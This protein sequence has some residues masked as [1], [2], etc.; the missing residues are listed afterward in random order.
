MR[1]MLE[2]KVGIE[3]GIDMSERVETNGQALEEVGRPPAL[4]GKAESPG[5]VA[6][7]VARI[8]YALLLLCFA[9]IALG[10]DGLHRLRCEYCH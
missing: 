1:K 2:F 4:L 5:I 7:P 3:S 6:D 10:R 8:N 9:M